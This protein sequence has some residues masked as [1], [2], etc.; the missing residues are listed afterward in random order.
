MRLVYFKV[1][2]RGH[3]TGR[4][5]PPSSRPRWRQQGNLCP[6]L[7]ICQPGREETQPVTWSWRTA[8]K[9]DKGG[10]FF[11]FLEKD[12]SACHGSSRIMYICRGGLTNPLRNPPVS[13]FMWTYIIFHY[14]F[15]FP[16]IFLLFFLYHYIMLMWL[17]IICHD[18]YLLFTY[19]SHLLVRLFEY[20]VYCM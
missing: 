9:S 15:F 3:V 4:L 16:T 12:R 19:W 14:I 11:F 6:A 2:P 1:V 17:S 5:S 20:F 8:V 18:P 7:C 10:I 13:I